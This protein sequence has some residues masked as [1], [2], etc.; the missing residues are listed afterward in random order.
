M[1][2]ADVSTDVVIVGAGPPGLLLALLLA[3]A[4]HAVHVLERQERFGPSP[5]G[6]V[7]QPG[8]LQIFDELGLLDGVRARSLQVDGIE[9]YAP[10]GLVFCRDYGAIPLVPHAFGLVVPLSALREALLRCVQDQPLIHLHLGAQVRELAERRPG[11]YAVGVQCAGSW[12][13]FAPAVVVAADGKFSAVRAMAGID[14][15]VEEFEHRHLVLRTLRPASW[16]ARMRAY[17]GGRFVFAVPGRRSLLHLLWLLPVEDIATLQRRGGQEMVA[18]LAALDPSLAGLRDLAPL[19]VSAVVPY[20]TVRPAT[21]HAGNVVLLGDA[22]HGVH[23]FGG[24][25]MNLALQDATLLAEVV[26][27]ALSSRDLD[28]LGRFQRMRKQYVEHFQNRQQQ[29][30][31]HNLARGRDDGMYADEW[32]ELALGQPDLRPWTLGVRS[33]SGRT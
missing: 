16:P 20:H 33:H 24:Q 11:R 13:S 1:K 5:A 18:R 26:D 25:G 28:A 9:E 19:E 14:C 4:G 29:A 30:L 7:L 10:S 21:W 23:S 27:R 31:R 15:Q 2:T 12:T 6:V 22:A 8:T 3:H 17:T 32:D